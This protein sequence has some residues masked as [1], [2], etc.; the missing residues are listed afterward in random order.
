MK[1]KAAIFFILLFLSSMTLGKGV[2]DYVAPPA[3]MYIL[4]G[5]V[6][7]KDGSPK[8]GAAVF[9][10][11]ATRDTSYISRQYDYARTNDSGI[12]TIMLNE[13]SGSQP[14]VRIVVTDGKDTTTSQWIFIDIASRQEETETITTSD[15]NSHKKIIPVA[16]KYTFPQQTIIF[17]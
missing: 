2:S 14:G 16:E 8:R 10:D 12:F 3:F 7:T 4:K 5:S 17:P 6:Q 11:I 1:N 15:C 13:S 9:F